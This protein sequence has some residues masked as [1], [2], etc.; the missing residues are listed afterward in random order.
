M[1]PDPHIE[2]VASEAGAARL[3]KAPRRPI[4]RPSGAIADRL[5][6][7]GYTIALGFVGFGALFLLWAIVAAL[8]PG[9]PTPIEAVTALVELLK[10]PFHDGGPND[11]GIGIQLITSLERVFIGFGIATVVAVPFGFLMG[12][13]KAA[14][15]MF[16]P[17]VQL[18]RPVSPLAWFPLGL[19]VLKAA[20]L[21]AIFVIFITS[22]WPTLLNTAFGVSSVPQSHKNVARVFQFSRTKYVR[23][24][25]LPYSLP[26]VVTGMRISMGIAWM[27]IVAAEM[28]S[29]GTGIGFYVWDAYNASNLADVAAAIFLIGFVGMALDFVFGRLQ[30]RVAYKEM[31]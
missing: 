5:S 19:V 12:A 27:V 1:T 3:D 17:V 28:L 9:L 30:A 18:L 13:S 24:V 8:S 22:I 11:K 21:A 16:N 15:A 26:S 2:A 4:A 31:V 29:G 10:S 7:A 20:P 6:S 25:L 23:H 14:W